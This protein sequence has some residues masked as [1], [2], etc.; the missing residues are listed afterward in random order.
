MRRVL[1][2]RGRVIGEVNNNN[3]QLFLTAIDNWRRA[4]QSGSCKFKEV[5]DDDFLFSDEIFWD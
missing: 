3:Y 4:G 5:E 1:K 2:D